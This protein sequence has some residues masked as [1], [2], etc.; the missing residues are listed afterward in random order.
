MADAA[1][2]TVDVKGEQQFG[3]QFASG[4]TIP[5][6]SQVI[7]RRDGVFLRNVV[8]AMGDNRINFQSV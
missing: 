7:Q 5:E 2:Q 4:I 3:V 1:R 6:S 8:R